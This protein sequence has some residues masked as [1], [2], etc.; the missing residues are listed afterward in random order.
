MMTVVVSVFTVRQEAPRRPQFLRW[1]TIAAFLLVAAGAFV[2]W[3]Y[4]SAR[5]QRLITAFTNPAKFATDGRP[6]RALP[7]HGEPPMTWLP[8][9]GFAGLVVPGLVIAWR[10]RRELRAEDLALVTG[11][12]VTVL[13]ITGPWFGA[14]KAVR[15]YLIALIPTIAVGAFGL[16]QVTSVR[17]R[18]CVYDVALVLGVGTAWPM[19][20][21][22]GKAI[23]DDAAMAELQSLGR[24]IPAAGRTLVCAQHGVE[25]WTAWLL[26][27][28][29][30]QYSALTESDWHAYDSI[31]FLQVKAGLRMP[32]L[33]R[34]PQGTGPESDRPAESDH[35]LPFSSH[36]R[37]MR[38]PLTAP[39]ANI[40][41]DGNHLRLARLVTPQSVTPP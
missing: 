20:R 30:A 1:L 23:L 6:M 39:E 24:K 40:L 31:L 10:R 7:G 19:L 33:P 37:P 14:D 9:L 32:P 12:A 3:R 17:L 29:I 41:H 15:F 25:W 11:L 5:I 26:H 22:S 34:P 28:P 38:R 4:D 16:M 35:G 2:L 21:T 27:T 13:A 8:F 18:R 36:Q